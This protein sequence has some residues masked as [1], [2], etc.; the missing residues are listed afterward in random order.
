MESTSYEKVG[1]DCQLV[2]FAFIFGIL[3]KNTDI[4]GTYLTIISPFDER[5]LD[6]IYS[7]L[8]TSFSDTVLFDIVY[9]NALLC[10]QIH[11]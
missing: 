7:G 5:A 9:G 1:V 8:I 2:I 6:D 4:F 10:G 3:L 11:T